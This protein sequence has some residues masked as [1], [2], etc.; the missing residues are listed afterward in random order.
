MMC[1][2]VIE[3]ILNAK[4]MDKEL[5]WSQFNRVE[6]CD[7]IK[8]KKLIPI[9]RKI[10]QKL[11]VEPYFLVKVTD[12]L[13]G[14]AHFPSY[15]ITNLY[16]PGRSKTVYLKYS[17]YIDDF[18]NSMSAEMIYDR[19]KSVYWNRDYN[20][21]IEIKTGKKWGKNLNVNNVVENE[22]TVLY[23]AKI[24]FTINVRLYHI[25]YSKR[26]IKF[27][28]YVKCIVKDMSKG[29]YYNKLD[30]YLDNGKYVGEIVLNGLDPML[31]SHCEEYKYT[32]NKYRDMARLGKLRVGTDN[33][34]IEEIVFEKKKKYTGMDISENTVSMQ[35]IVSAYEENKNNTCWN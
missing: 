12:E 33:E 10:A 6:Y 9:I 3:Y 7:A 28:I 14:V 18:L 27:V 13:E 34:F 1:G 19:W 21:N 26:R 5:F 8:A 24:S 16:E 35:S 20:A 23:A 2:D 4:N 22:H 15:D 30:F 25:F 31:E 32:I 11:D 17:K 29:L